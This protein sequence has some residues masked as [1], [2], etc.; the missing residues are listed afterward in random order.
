MKRIV[1]TLI[2]SVILT[3]AVF[4]AHGTDET[5]KTYKIGDKGPAGGWIFYDNGS[6]TRGWR[7]LEAAA[8]DQ[9]EEAVWGGDGAIASKSTAIEIGAGK[10]NTNKI[11]KVFGNGS[12]AAKL[13]AD[14]R[15]GGKN[16]WFLPS[17]NELNLMYTNLKAKG[18][19]G[20]SD[21]D[22]WSSSEASE[23]YAWYQSFVDGSK[24]NNTKT[25]RLYVRA[26]RA[27]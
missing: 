5:I 13:C 6:S 11:I 27:F 3:F 10:A 17:K 22:Y 25:N 21:T 18:I 26:I 16:D 14:Y 7:Y 2:S 4:S 9:S 12:Y 1:I 15:G 23:P 8:T 19:G 24:D 20:F